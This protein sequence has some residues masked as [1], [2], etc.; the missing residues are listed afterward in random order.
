[1]LYSRIIREVTHD[2]PNYGTL[3]GRGGG[4]VVFKIQN[5]TNSSYNCFGQ[6]ILYKTKQN[7]TKYRGGHSFL[8]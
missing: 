4:R 3:G 1:M 5:W 6:N 2:W 7:L 8:A